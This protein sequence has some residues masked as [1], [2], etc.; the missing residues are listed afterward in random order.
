[1]VQF[2]GLIQLGLSPTHLSM[3]KRLF[4]SDGG[5]RLPLR[6][7][8]TAH[9]R[10]ESASSP[11]A[12]GPFSEAMKMDWSKGMLSSSQVQ[13]YCSAAIHEGNSSAA[14][15]AFASAGGA[16]SQ[17]SHAQRDIVRKLGRPLGSPDLYFAVPRI[18]VAA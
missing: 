10:E 17:P 9:P 8:L 4:G 1:M 6:S 7:R 2:L 14:V 3:L 5:G 11:K 12:P 15:H 13:Q 18:L 16:G